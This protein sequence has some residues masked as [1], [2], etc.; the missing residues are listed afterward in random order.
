MF[1][2]H[3]MIFHAA[4][5]RVEAPSSTDIIAVCI[6]ARRA[7]KTLSVRSLCPCCRGT[8]TQRVQARQ[9][10]KSFRIAQCPNCDGH[11]RLNWCTAGVDAHGNQWALMQANA[12]LK[13]QPS[14]A[15]NPLPPA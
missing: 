2:R 1:A 4:R 9:L 8:G 13:L 14:P 7:G 10:L 12:V 11:G 3:H 5:T 6:P 15:L